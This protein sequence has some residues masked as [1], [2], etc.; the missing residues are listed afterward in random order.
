[1]NSQQEQQITKY[2]NKIND[3]IKAIEKHINHIDGI[4]KYLRNARFDILFAMHL[5]KIDGEENG[6]EEIIQHKDEGQK[7]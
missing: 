1:M 3:D 2:L 7:S 6:K 5:L 4:S